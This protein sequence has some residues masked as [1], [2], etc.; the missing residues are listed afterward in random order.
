MIA[1]LISGYLRIAAKLVS[2]Y[3]RIA[4]KLWG[5][6]SSSSVVVVE[7]VSSSIPVP[8]KCTSESTLQHSTV[9]IHTKPSSTVDENK[10][11][12]SDSRNFKLACLEH[13]KM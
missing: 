6:L 3:L 10:P 8:L 2:G 13:K 7:V 1:E 5:C 11:A 12:F 4:A 9:H